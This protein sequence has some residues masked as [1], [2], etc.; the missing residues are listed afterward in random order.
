MVPHLTPAERSALLI[1]VRP[2]TPEPVFQAV[3]S[4]IKPHLREQEWRRLC[5]Q[6]GLAVP[7]KRTQGRSEGEGEGE[8]EAMQLV[9]RFVDAAFIRFDADAVMALVTADF[10]AHPWVAMGVP[11]GP[12]GIQYIV[13]AFR[14]AFADARATIEDVVTQ[15]DRV[16]VR[17]TY[18][19]R[20]AGSL[21]GLP[22]TQRSFRM[23]GILIA[24]VEGDK[25]AE[26]W[27]EEDMLGLQQQLG[28][29]SL[30]VA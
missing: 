12:D 8:G 20:H 4:L 5:E 27:R 3:M 14:T 13:G 29:A 19:G 26:Y 21:F 17:Y 30:L 25:V 9:E 7:V 11:P 18:E 23:H 10:V 22:A 15:G 1:G 24:R 6:L 2:T 16:V 28:V